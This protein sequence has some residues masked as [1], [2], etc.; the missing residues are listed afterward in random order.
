MKPRLRYLSALLVNVALPWLAYR[1]AFPHWGLQGGLVASALPPVAWMTL[2]L[3]RYRHFDALSALVLAGIA[4][5]LIAL[6]AGGDV[7]LK[8]LEDPMV[9]GMIGAS[10]LVSLALAAF[11]NSEIIGYDA[12]L[13]LGNFDS[14]RIAGLATVA[15]ALLLWF[16]HKGYY[17]VRMNFWAEAK[18][19]ITAFAVAAPPWP[20]RMVTYSRYSPPPAGSL[21]VADPASEATIASV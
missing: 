5:S 1:L 21:I 9:S 4:L 20:S 18:A 7:R 16:Q 13:P 12:L 15:T 8:S 11:V 3:A 17:R 6:A 2:D 19:V 10:F 14:I